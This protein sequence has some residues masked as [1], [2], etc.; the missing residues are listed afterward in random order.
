MLQEKRKPGDGPVKDDNKGGRV[1]I[2]DPSDVLDD[3]EELL[4]RAKKQQRKEEEGGCG[5]W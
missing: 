2:I 1:Q 5:C 4:K 3:T